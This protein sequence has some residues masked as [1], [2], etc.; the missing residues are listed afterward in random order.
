MTGRVFKRCSCPPVLDDAG[1]RKNCQKRH[2]SW[3]FMHDVRDSSGKRRQ[4]QRGGFATAADAEAALQASLTATGM[5]VRVQ[6]QR[7]LTVAAYLEAWLERKKDTGRFRPS[8]ALHTGHHVHHY[9]IP[10]MGHYRLADLTVD[11]V[12]RALASLRRQDTRKRQ[13]SASSVRRIHATL[14][15]ALN[16]AVRRRMIPYNPASLAE[17]EPTRRPKV[18]PWEPEELGAFLDHAAGHRLGVLFEVLA[19]TGLRRGEIVGLR[20]RDVDLD[21]GALWVRQ[22]VVQVGY[23]SIVGQPKTAS[24]EDRR[25]DLDAAT[26][27][28]LIAHRLQQDAEKD[29]FG[30]AYEDN[31]LVFPRED[32][33]HLKPEA[34]SNTFQRLIAQAGLRRVRLHD[35]RHGQASIMLAAG[36]EM[37]VVSKRLGHSGIRIT[38]DTYTHLLE[39]VGRQAAEAA[40]ALIPRGSSGEA[41]ARDQR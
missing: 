18:R 37:A 13:L 26:V 4:V 34:V 39:G 11:D 31:D 41:R 38:S 30:T 7:R 8:T 25:V 1:R 20:W 22:S 17:L 3:F 6:E 36:V 16:D 2:G 5:G 15:S 21:R 40:A 29:A 24:G 10:L 33:S 12:D 32:G 28:S 23:T 27:G 9:W 35:L 19:M 14:R